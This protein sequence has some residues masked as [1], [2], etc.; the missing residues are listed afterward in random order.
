LTDT[1]HEHES[2]TRTRNSERKGIWATDRKAPER[3]EKGISM[4]YIGGIYLLIVGLYEPRWIQIGG[5]GY[6]LFRRGFY[7]YV[8]SALRG[9]RSRLDR[10]LKDVKKLHWHIDYF[11]QYGTIEAVAYGEC[12]QNEE[13]ALANQL[14]SIFQ[15]IPGFGSSDCRC[16]SHLFFSHLR[17]PLMRTGYSS[18]RRIGLTPRPYWKKPYIRAF[19]VN[20]EDGRIW[21]LQGGNDSRA[22][23]RGERI[24]KYGRLIT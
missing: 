6:R 7:G 23:C 13:C 11:L 21:D 20:L 2:R 3:I 15:S 10:H 17:S 19:D 22:G 12:R 18:F 8:G 24:K 5:L 1:D 14:S 9:M 4:A 16:S